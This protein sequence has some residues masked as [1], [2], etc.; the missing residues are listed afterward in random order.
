M[1]FREYVTEFMNE[2][3]SQKRVWRI[4]GVSDLQKGAYGLLA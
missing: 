3:L 1:S 2:I 4:E